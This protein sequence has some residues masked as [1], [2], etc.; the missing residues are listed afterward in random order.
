MSVSI[1]VRKCKILDVWTEIA[2]NHKKLLNL[3]WNLKIMGALTSRQNADVEET[4][5]GSNHAYKYPPKSGKCEI[6]IF[7]FGWILND[8]LCTCVVE[9]AS[10]KSNKFVISFY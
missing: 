1:F 2:K 6:Q 4:D 3:V 9:M 7:L 5:V 10:T 8:V